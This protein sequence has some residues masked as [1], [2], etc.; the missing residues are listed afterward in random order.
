MD[1]SPFV[2]TPAQLP[3][4]AAPVEPIAPIAPAAKS[5]KGAATDSSTSEQQKGNA[6]ESS[7][8]KALKALND[9]MQAWST[10]LQFSVDPDLHRVVV[11]VVDP[12]TGKTLKTIPSEAVLR[13]A[14]MLT[15]LDGKGVKAEA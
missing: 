15:K 7:I 1:V 9:E 10:Q 2:A 3:V 4:H 8:D 12:D 13:I 5:D 11:T 14:K 6:G